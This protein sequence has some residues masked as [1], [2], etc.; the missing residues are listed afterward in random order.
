MSHKNQ[1][2]FLIVFYVYVLFSIEYDKIYIGYSQNIDARLVSH[3][4]PRNRGW[5]SRYRPWIIVHKEN[6]QSK[7]EALQREKQLKSS[8]GRLYIRNLLSEKLKGG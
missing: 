5:T 4:D 6:F 8:K 7:R 3:N 2:C 1:P